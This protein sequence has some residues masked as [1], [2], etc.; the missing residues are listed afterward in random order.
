[1]RHLFISMATLLSLILAAPVVA[2]SVSGAGA[3]EGTPAQTRAISETQIAQRHRHQ[4]GNV[5]QH[6]YKHDDHHR[7]QRYDWH[8]YHPGKRPPDWDRHRQLNRRSWQYNRRAERRY[9]WH[10]YN[11]PRHWKYRRWGF[12]M[13]LPSPFWVRQY[14]ITNYWQFGLPNPPYG[15]VWVRYGNDALLINVRSGQILQVVYG[16]FY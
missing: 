5:R 7:Y 1:M 6:H 10:R 4:D 12:G 11:P 2:E 8:R 9:R 15:Y 3:D 16:L 13:I 14:W